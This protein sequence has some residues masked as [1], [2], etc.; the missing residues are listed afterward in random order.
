[1]A[2]LRERVVEKL[3]SYT[4]AGRGEELFTDEE[5]VAIARKN[6][7]ARGR[8]RAPNASCR[9]PNPNVALAP[10]ANR[11]LPTLRRAPPPSPPLSR[12]STVCLRTLSA[13]VDLGAER[14]ALCRCVRALAA[15][16]SRAAQHVSP[17]PLASRA[18][19]A[20]WPPSLFARAEKIV[21]SEPSDHRNKLRVWIGLSCGGASLLAAAL[22][23]WNIIF[24][25]HWRSMQGLTV[26]NPEAG[27]WYD[28]PA[29]IL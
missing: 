11:S 2:A 8:C 6:E 19:P 26:V 14:P 25:L 1:M 18:H 12:P 13:T 4:P 5:D 29:A 9:A 20:A 15:A 7:S 28:A 27:G 22:I 3:R 17:P 21:F 16:A 24:Q 10:H 23:V